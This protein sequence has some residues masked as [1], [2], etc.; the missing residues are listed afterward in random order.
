MIFQLDT[1]S[2]GNKNKNKN[3]DDNTK[4]KTTCKG[5]HQRNKRHSTEW[6][7]IYANYFY[8]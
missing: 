4:S 3:K 6:E 8:Y 7:E 5:N 2:K 1:E